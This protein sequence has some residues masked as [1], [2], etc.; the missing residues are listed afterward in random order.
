ML[1]TVSGLTGSLSSVVLNNGVDISVYFNLLEV[2]S[3]CLDG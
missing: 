1:W 2:G 3:D